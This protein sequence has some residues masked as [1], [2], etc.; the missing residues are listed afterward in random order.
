MN[1]MRDAFATQR[2]QLI[3]KCLCWLEMPHQS[4]RPNNKTIRRTPR[5]QISKFETCKV[6][7]S[8]N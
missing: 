3:L 8:G 5:K 2:F 1:E 4:R 6:I 7:F